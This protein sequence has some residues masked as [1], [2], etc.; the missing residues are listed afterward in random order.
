MMT[1]DTDD[2]TSDSEVEAGPRTRHRK[3]AN[4]VYRGYQVRC[5]EFDDWI[6][7]HNMYFCYCVYILL[8]LCSVSMLVI[9]D[10]DVHQVEC[11]P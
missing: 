4:A 6:C 9:D 5:G 7:V 3:V 2:F 11:Y 10:D 8:L 1:D